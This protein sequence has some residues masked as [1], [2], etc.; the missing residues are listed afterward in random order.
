[1]EKFVQCF[2]V[3]TTFCLVCSI[4]VFWLPPTTP[5]FI[6][7]R[8]ALSVLMLVI[9]RNYAVVGN[10]ELPAGTPYNWY[11]LLCMNVQLNMSMIVFWN[12]FILTAAQ[13]L[14]CTT[15]AKAV[16]GEL[17]AVA[18]MIVFATF[19][20]IFA[21]A[22]PNSALNLPAVALIVG[23]IFLLSNVIYIGCVSSTLA[24]ERAHNKFLGKTQVSFN[25]SSIQP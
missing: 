14:G 21:G 5:M 13:G 25:E 22:G 3:P 1:M 20:A 8:L 24:A 11:D 12:I 6:T 9:F 2:L 16:N 19:A 4:A 23:F 7:P 15:T 10:E 17:K 18:P